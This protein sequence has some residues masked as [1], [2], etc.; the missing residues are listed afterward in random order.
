MSGPRIVIAGGGL[1][2]VR[3]AQSVRDL[4]HR[5]E[6][7]ILSAETEA[8][9]D[10]PP[11]SK[12]YLLGTLADDAIRL[13]GPS[14]YRSLGIGL[15]L[16]RPA[17]ALDTVAHTVTVAD[18]TVVP[19][20][21]LV[22]AT[23]ARARPLGVVTGRAAA[24]ALRTAADARGLAAVLRDGRRIAVIGG[25][26]IGLEVAATA[27]ARGC[28]VTVVEAQPAPLLGTVGPL[29]AGWLRSRHVAHGVEFR[30][31]VTVTAAGAAPGGGERL[32]LADGSVVDAD[33][34]VVGVGVVRDVGWLA[35]AGLEVADGLVCDLAGRT[36]APD[37]F[38]AGDVVCHRTEH[39]LAPVG[40][41][42]AAGNSARRVAHTLLGLP[43]PDLLDDGFFWSDQLGLR[44]QF[45][46][47]ADAGSEFV[48]VAGDMATDSFA[49]HFRAEG[50][51]TGV[52]AVN[53]PRQFLRSRKE[54]RVAHAS[55]TVREV[56]R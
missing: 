15:E 48:V 5:G 28:A 3:T 17:V 35:E 1:A 16:G 38:G 2:A 9:Y 36:G 40:H 10:R 32:G 20:D 27:R 4:G 54:L 42:T 44:L 21:R 26:F 47:R 13:L 45:A 52:F 30:C 39:G 22:I 29:V 46:G 56:L 25:G 7:R 14:G 55:T 8:P 24:S 23:G 41:W 37:V 49:G 34:V 53:S 33:A 6:V 12:E 31:G 11:L 51:I 50:R 43:A 19:Y 18:G